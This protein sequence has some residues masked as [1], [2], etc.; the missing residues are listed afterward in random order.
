VRRAIE[1]RVVDG[2]VDVDPTSRIAH[3]A[4]ALRSA[5]QRM[6]DLA[7]DPACAA[8]APV[9]LVAVGEALIAL[10]GTAYAAAHAL[11]PPAHDDEGITDRYARAATIW[12]SPR[13]GVGPSHEQQ[14]RVLASLHDAGAAL[15]A[16]AERC[17]RA[18]ETVAATMEPIERRLQRYERRSEAA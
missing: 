4:D 1:A 6:Q 13:G 7:L 16:A 15:R 8:L 12:P 17:G 2:L 14:A 5:A 18:A 11:V 10:S 3:D 9:S